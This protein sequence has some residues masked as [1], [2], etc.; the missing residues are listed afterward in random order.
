M[1]IAI[2]LFSCEDESGSVVENSNASNP[3]QLDF[4][5]SQMEVQ[6]SAASKL[7]GWSDYQVFK[8]AFREYN[9][10]PAATRQLFDYATAMAENVPQNL[11]QAKFV[12]RIK[13]L[14]TR[15]GI[16]NSYLNYNE[17]KDSLRIKKYGDI[18]E[19]WDELNHHFNDQI[20]EIDRQKAALEELLRN[21]NRNDSITRARRDSILQP[22][23]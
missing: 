6:G 4:P 12:S 9:Q 20:N 14:R 19:A 18:V 1:L 23:Q 22:E 11:Q 10:S 5:Q 13:L 21:E 7:A 2:A 15:L 16:Y 3:S 17:V 8:D